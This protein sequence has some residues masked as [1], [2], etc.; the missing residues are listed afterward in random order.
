M[1]IACKFV[2]LLIAYRFLV[3]RFADADN[4][5][6]GRKPFASALSRSYPYL[7]VKND[8]PV[9]FCGSFFVLCPA[10]PAGTLSMGVLPGCDSRTGQPAL[11]SN[12]TRFIHS[13]ELQWVRS[14]ERRVGKECRSR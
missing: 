11:W 6:P 1:Q 12:E 8:P 2:R 10:P 9:G 14:E 3:S 5:S 4:E 13:G 7:L